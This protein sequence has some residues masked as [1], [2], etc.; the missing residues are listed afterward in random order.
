MKQALQP[1][2]VW[3]VYGVVRILNANRKTE[4]NKTDDP[5]QERSFNTLGE[6][7]Q[8]YYKTVYILPKLH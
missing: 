8:Q 3:P 1:E 4:K 2:L 7:I 5:L 6:A